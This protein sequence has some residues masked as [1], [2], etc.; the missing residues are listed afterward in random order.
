MK[1]LL[2]IRIGIHDF[3]LLVLVDAGLLP[4]GQTLVLI[5]GGV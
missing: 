1:M 3:Y 2:I 4:D 5:L